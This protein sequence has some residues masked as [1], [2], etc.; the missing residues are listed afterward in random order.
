MQLKYF[1]EG[2]LSLR[3]CEP[4]DAKLLYKWENDPLLAVSNLLSEP[5][6]RFQSRELVSAGE[7]ELARN[8][9][10][11]LIAEI[12]SQ[13]KSEQ[14]IPIG[15][16]ELYNYDFFNRRVALGILILPDYRRCGYGSRLIAMISGYVLKSLGMHQCYAEVSAHNTTAQA[17]FEKVGF[18]LT[19][20]LP[21][22]YRG[23]EGYEA[24][25]LLVLK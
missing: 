10:M 21:D 23:D 15:F 2:E 16:I 19:A 25:N 20:T 22:W 7:S 17:C 18:K 1:I 12:K 14:A 11:P 9:F 24:L 5:L 3:R 6:A 13:A 4:E 8:G